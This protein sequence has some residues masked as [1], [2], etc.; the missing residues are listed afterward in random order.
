MQNISKKVLEMDQVK[1]QAIEK[2]KKVISCLVLN[3]PLSSIFSKTGG[4]GGTWICFCPST[5]V[6]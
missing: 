3:R 5:V 4:S 6:P 1:Q 2:E